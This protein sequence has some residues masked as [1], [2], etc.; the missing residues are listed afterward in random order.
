MDATVRVPWP[1]VVTRKLAWSSGPGFALCDT[2]PSLKTPTERKRGSMKRPPS[3]YAKPKIDED[4]TQ[5]DR[6]TELLKQKGPVS[7]DMIA[8]A[9]VRDL[10]RDITQSL[11]EFFVEGPLDQVWCYDLFHLENF[12]SADTRDAYLNELM[13]A[14]S[15]EPDE[16]QQ[17][18]VLS[19]IRRD[20]VQYLIS[21][22]RQRM[23]DALFREANRNRGYGFAGALERL[24]SG[25]PLEQRHAV[26]TML[27][28]FGVDC[29]ADPS[30]PIISQRYLEHTRTN[31]K[32]QTGVPRHADDAIQDAWQGRE[33]PSATRAHLACAPARRHPHASEGGLDCDGAETGPTERR[34]QNRDA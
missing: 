23:L 31:R 7:I 29:L 25:S 18:K 13:R 3:Y 11:V 22:V 17:Q 34:C 24:E 12:P 33:A 21:I 20:V 32:F 10:P 6:L 15:T 30:F 5:P 2:V 28:A 26:L 19:H 14:Y 4:S 9:Y 8:E 16:M 1:S 27:K